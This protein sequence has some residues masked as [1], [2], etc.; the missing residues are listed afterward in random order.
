M[1]LARWGLM[2]ELVPMRFFSLT[3]GYGGTQL[4]AIQSL[5]SCGDVQGQ[6]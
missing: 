4:I 6:R 1:G 2:K 3:K 5:L